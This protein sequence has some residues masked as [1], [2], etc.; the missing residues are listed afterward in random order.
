MVRV[1]IIGAGKNATKHAEYCCENRDR[2]KVVAIA[3]PDMDRADRLAKACSA[4]PV[5]EYTKMLP[6]VD[7]VFI[8]SPN[9][10]HRSQ[11]ITAAEAGKH[12]YCEKPVGLSVEDAQ[13]MA[14]AAAAA[15]VRTLVGFS[16]RKAGNIRTMA[17]MAQSGDLGDLLTVVSRRV[18]ALHRDAETAW[19]VNPETSGGLL[20]EVNIHEID[21][22]MMVAGQVES[23]YA[24]LRA[25]E[26]RPRAND[27][28]AV[29]LNFA[30]GAIGIHEGSWRAPLPSFFRCV[31]GN[32]AGL[33]TDEWGKGLML[34]ALG[35]DRCEIEC[36]EDLDMRAAFFDS[37]ESGVDCDCNLA[38]GLE[39]MRVTEAIYESSLTNQVVQVASAAASV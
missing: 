35:S 36:D 16:V 22:M 30:N 29:T 10:F 11:V 28:I 8:S 20:L 23:V 3:D 26:K 9:H 33:Q 32:R 21:W 17:R 18:F 13:A 19:R 38:Y 1:G 2:V 15:D 14:D 4:K 37:I 7:A 39:V 31:Y 24:R 34:G 12:I 5:D 25:D 6:D 27:H